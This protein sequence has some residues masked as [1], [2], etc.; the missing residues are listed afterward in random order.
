[1]IFKL[2]LFYYKNEWCETLSEFKKNKL[3][4]LQINIFKI[5]IDDI[6]D[7]IIFIYK[8]NYCLYTL[9]RQVLLLYID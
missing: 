7:L 3:V 2:K 4:Y 5:N 6:N 9:Y 1:M 8:F